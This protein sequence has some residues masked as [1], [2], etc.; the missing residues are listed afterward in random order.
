MRVH[1]PTLAAFA[2]RVD[3][4][5]DALAA[6]ALG[7]GA[8]QRG[9]RQRGGIQRDLVGS[10]T[11]ETAHVVDR[12]DATPDRER[13]VDTLGGA[14]D[15]VEHGAPVFVRRGDV[16]KHEL[17]GALCVVGEGRLD[18]IAGVTQ[19]DEAH[20]LDD[21]AVFHVEARDDTLRQHQ[22]TPRTAAIAAGRSTA[23]V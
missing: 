10:R 17:V 19:I 8:D 14:P 18:G 9:L 22:R 21:A 15:D 16:E 13:H 20:A 6:E 4:H 12:A 1:A 5:H 23:P 3:R 11:E 2:S 7:R